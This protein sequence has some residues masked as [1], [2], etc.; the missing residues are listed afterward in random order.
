MK[1]TPREVAAHDKPVRG[2]LGLLLTLAAVQF[3]HIVD[4]MIMMPLGPQF[5]RLFAIGPQAFGLLVSAYTF[6]A[7]ASGFIAAFW[8]DRYD[9]KRALLALYGGFIIATALCGFATNYPLLLA[10]RV[11]A[12]AFGGVM[13]GLVFAIVADAVPY[14][15]RARATAIVAASFSFAA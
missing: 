9:H 6:G 14:G 13:G 15:R 4:F 1:E 12:G 3:T 11:V 8:I 10:A 7:A 5:M 2:E